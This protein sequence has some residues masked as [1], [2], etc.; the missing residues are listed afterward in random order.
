ML[1]QNYLPVCLGW[2]T[3]VAVST[4][5]PPALSES[6]LLSDIMDSHGLGGAFWPGWVFVIL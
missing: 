3:V 1:R 6:E 2:A 5:A 4:Q